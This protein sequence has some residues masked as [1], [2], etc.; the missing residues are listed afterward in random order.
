M[1]TMNKQKK[2]GVTKK[3]IGTRLLLF[4]VALRIT[5]GLNRNSMR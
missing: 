4:P 3:T 5:T 1:I 2:H